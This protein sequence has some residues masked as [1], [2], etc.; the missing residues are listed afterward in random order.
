VIAHRVRNRPENLVRFEIAQID[1]GDPVVGDIV[2]EQPTTIV[3][4]IGLRQGWVM[5]V[6][7]GEIAKQLFRF[8]IEP[9]TGAWIWREDGNGADVPQR[10]NAGDENLAGMTAGIE[11]IIF[12]LLSGRDV[13]GQCI[14]GAIS[15][16][17]AAFAAAHKAHGRDDDRERDQMFIGCFHCLSF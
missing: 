13:T 14:R 12:V 10:W 3:F 9:V 6:A 8:L 17:G 7:P 15:L 2:Y 5:D 4:G 11:K 16:T 1:P